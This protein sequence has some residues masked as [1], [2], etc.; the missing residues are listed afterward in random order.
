M[1]PER[2]RPPEVEER[3]R[4]LYIVEGRSAEE[5]A[6]IMGGGETRHAIIALGNHRGWEAKGRRGKAKSTKFV[7]APRGKVWPAPETA[8]TFV[9]RPLN[10]CR[11]PVGPEPANGDMSLHLACARPADGT[12]CQEHTKAASGGKPNV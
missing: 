4:Q 7:A 5:T 8:V 6:R 1:T 2:K 12:Y 9:D 11:W 10:G 3:I